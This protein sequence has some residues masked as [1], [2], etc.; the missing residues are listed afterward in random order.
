MN[1]KF[2]LISFTLV[3]M[4]MFSA[5]NNGN[6]SN[7]N[8]DQQVDADTIQ[9][10]IGDVKLDTTIIGSTSGLISMVVGGAEK[11]VGEQ[12]VLWLLDKVSGGSFPPNQTQTLLSNINGQLANIESQISAENALIGLVYDTINEYQYQNQFLA[13]NDYENGIATYYNV[14][15]VYLANQNNFK[16]VKINSNTPINIPKA[17]L[18]VAES[19]F[20]FES[21]AP[22]ESVILQAMT[23]NN[24]QKTLVAR[25]GAFTTLDNYGMELSCD[26]SSQYS[27]SDQSLHIPPT[28]S[29]TNGNCA[30]INALNAKLNNF[31]L[32][33][34]FTNGQ[35]AFYTYTSFSAGL[36]LVYLQM[37]NALTQEYAVDQIRVY[38]GQHA[39]SK[40]GS[41]SYVANPGSYQTALA[42][43]TL[44]YNSR[45]NYLNT[46]FTEAKES[47]LN[48]VISSTPALSL[49][50]IP[51]QCS[52]N[53]KNIESSVPANVN[54]SQASNLYYWD[55]STLTVTCNS[56][57]NNPLT[58]TTSV[59]TMCLNPNLQVINGF[60]SCGSSINNYMFS[61]AYDNKGLGELSSLALDYSSVKNYTTYG[62]TAFF[63]QLYSFGTIGTLDVYY[64]PNYPI[65]SNGFD[66]V[67]NV[68]TQS[69]NN[70]FGYQFYSDGTG[71]A[72]GVK[73]GS[74]VQGLP[75]I[76]S[77]GIHAF[78]L[79]AGAID[80][81][82]SDN[83]GYMLL[84]CLPDDSNCQVG[85]FVNFTNQLEA[86]NALIFRNGDVIT[87]Y[88][89][90]R[91]DGNG[92]HGDYYLQNYYNG[93]AAQ[94]VPY[95]V[96]AI[97]W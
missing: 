89:L 8:N 94:Q 18:A 79:S 92:Y 97:S 50:S 78:T 64:D 16:N 86:Y 76:V 21:S 46:I 57:G 13:I 9:P 14:I 5:C 34:Q 36:D 63:A 67:V 73:P 25:A 6:S 75:A 55:G 82:F 42:D 41:P 84:G 77:D 39:N 71:F 10:V 2:K 38:L 66:S 20:L 87:M 33:F 1:K 88:N 81:D 47:A 69:M 91:N 53:S 29:L 80:H 43:V 68:Y 12:A 51:A 85:N 3:S 7:N 90:N 62:I 28:I 35:N 49:E 17:A 74:S 44:A 52:I 72:V 19:A 37:L 31:N 24:A 30:L 60:I 26:T 15:Y 59:A 40:V 83:Q 4:F 32:N 65:T 27:N 93:T 56:N 54:A 61:Q 58:T 45:M 23:T 22:F 95:I 96:N 70:Q 48:F 11:E